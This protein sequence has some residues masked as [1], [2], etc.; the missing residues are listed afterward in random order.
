MFSKAT[1]LPG[2]SPGGGTRH[3]LVYP[4]IVATNLQVLNVWKVGSLNRCF[5]NAYIFSGFCLKY[6]PSKA[7]T[8]SVMRIQGMFGRF[9]NRTFEFFEPNMW[10]QPPFTAYIQDNRLGACFIV[11]K[12]RFVDKITCLVTLLTC[13][14]LRSLH[15]F[16]TFR[17][18]W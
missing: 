8:D 17:V 14:T 15:D 6:Y 3:W 12:A 18:N 4:G 13:S 1:T 5:F 7:D 11:V 9:S 2:I 10:I 16:A